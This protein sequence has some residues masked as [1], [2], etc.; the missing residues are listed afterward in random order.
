MQVRWQTKPIE[1]RSLYVPSN[2]CTQ[3]VI[4][5]WVDI[6]KP[7]QAN[8]FPPDDVSLPPT[9]IF[10]V[11][12]VIWKSRDVPAM[13]SLEGICEGKSFTFACFYF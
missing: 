5:L 6:M 2:K 4:E 8:A 3:G 11:R 13:D 7:E 12:V 10:E 1:R 9:Q